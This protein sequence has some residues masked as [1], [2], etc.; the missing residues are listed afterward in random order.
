MKRISRLMCLII[1]VLMF[2]AMF[3]VT[4]AAKYEIVDIS[5][6]LNVKY[7]GCWYGGE[8]ITIFPGEYGWSKWVS[9]VNLEYEGVPFKLAPESNKVHMWAAPQQAESILTVPVGKKVSNV[10]FLSAGGWTPPDKD[11]QILDARLFAVELEYA[12]GTVVVDLPTEYLK[13][14]KRI[15]DW[16][17]RSDSTDPVGTPAFAAVEADGRECLYTYVMEADPTKELKE[18]RFHK[19]YND[20]EVEESPDN[21]TVVVAA[22][23]L[24]LP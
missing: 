11:Y 7:S 9:D 12:D 20:P 18:V 1:V 16:A 6:D 22:V 15:M 19:F 2:T 21:S 23:T 3:A 24:E 4:A 5:K 10:F 8:R 14:V 17:I 13:G